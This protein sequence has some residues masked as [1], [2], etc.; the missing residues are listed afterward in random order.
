MYAE[1]RNRGFYWVPL[2]SLYEMDIPS[3][4]PRFC[5]NKS[6]FL[7]VERK[8][9]PQLTSNPTQSGH[10]Y[11]HTEYSYYICFSLRRSVYQIAV[12]QGPSYEYSVWIYLLPSFH[13]NL[14]DSKG[15]AVPLQAQRGPEVSRKLRFPDFVTMA[16]DGGR[17][18][19]LRTGRL[20][21]QEI[22]LVLISVRGWVDPMV[23]VRS[24]GFYVNENSN[25]TSC[26]RTSDVPICSY[27]GPQFSRQ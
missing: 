1:D 19:A 8:D 25:D 16:Q 17:V 10:F 11:G 13:C 23:I 15:K 4:Y 27:R 22:F 18:S 3:R 24:E 14:A 7:L 2:Q 21:P 6:F 20:Y 9:P 5:G 12:F 26:I